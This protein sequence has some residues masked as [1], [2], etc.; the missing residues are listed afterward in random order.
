MNGNKN[1]KTI[2]DNYYKDTQKIKYFLS[3]KV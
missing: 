3:F 1:E 2:K